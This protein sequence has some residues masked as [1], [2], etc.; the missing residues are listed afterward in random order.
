MMVILARYRF[1]CRLFLPFV[2]HGNLFIC[3][4][5]FPAGSVL[6]LAW[7]KDRKKAI[8]KL[9]EEW[10]IGHRTRALKAIRIDKYHSTV[11]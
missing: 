9:H 10:S 2:S 7:V 4:L 11:C 5:L 1:P 6:E 8:S 3:F